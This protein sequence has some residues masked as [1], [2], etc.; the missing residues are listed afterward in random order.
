MP[1]ATQED[2]NRLFQDLQEDSTLGL[3]FLVLTGSACIIATIGLLTNSAAVIIGA[4]IIAPLMMPL[5]GLAL[6][7]IEGNLNL[8]KE[9]LKTLSIGTI[10][11]ITLSCLI[12]RLINLPAS[13]FTPEILARTQPQLGDLGVAVAAGAVS[14]FAK[15]RPKITDAVAG[16]AIAV[17][18]MPPLCVVGISLSQAYW[19]ASWGA[20]LLFFTNLLGITLACMIVFILGGYYIETQRVKRAL[21]VALALTAI[22]I[23]PLT[24][25]LLQLIKQTQLQANVKKL[26]LNRTITVG[27][28]V[29]LTKTNVNWQKHPPEVTLTVLAKEPITPNQ[30]RLVEQF[31]Y[32]EMKQP[33]KLVFQVSEVREVRANDNQPQQE[34]DKKSPTP[35]KR[36]NKK[37][38]L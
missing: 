26:L 10:F 23:I 7:A 25:A 34:T 35:L 27:Q 5:R 9:S 31:L 37:I 12:G 29:E 16:T 15:L 21:R 18:L 4:M 30:V 20:F 1:K 11:A 36:P 17:A 19:T 38:K 22:L 2:I 8:F 24:L 14:G 32:R 6:G 13:E 28:K 3:N 33:F